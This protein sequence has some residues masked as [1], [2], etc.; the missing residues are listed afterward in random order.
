MIYKL[1][2]T[3][4]VTATYLQRIRNEMLFGMAGEPHTI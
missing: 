2:L 3:G 1:R 4:N